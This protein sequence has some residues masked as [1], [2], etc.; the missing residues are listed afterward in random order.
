MQDA[1]PASRIWRALWSGTPLPR[2]AGNLGP[3]FRVPQVPNCRR[4][5]FRTMLV[6]GRCDGARHR[7]K[8]AGSG[9]A[10]FRPSAVASD[11]TRRRLV[12][13][14]F[15][16]FGRSRYF[17]ARANRRGLVA[18]DGQYPAHVSRRIADRSSFHLDCRGWYRRCHAIRSL[19]RA[20]CPDRLASAPRV[21]DHSASRC[22]LDR[23]GRRQREGTLQRRKLLANRDSLAAIGGSRPPVAMDCWW[24]VPTPGPR[25]GRT[26]RSSVATPRPDSPANS[27]CDRPPAGM[28]IA[29]V[30][31]GPSLD[32]LVQRRRGPLGSA[33]VAG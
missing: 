8:K 13:R 10:E 20:A 12:E 32:A 6:L 18:L 3:D 11:T 15:V 29:G 26:P 22:D 2:T 25:S 27:G 17:R 19:D 23:L 9:I 1:T 16:Q 30:Y 7:G 24:S 21:G 31:P 14:P 4:T 28:E 5:G 33:G